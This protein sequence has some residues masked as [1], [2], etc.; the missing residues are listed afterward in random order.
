MS[1]SE[2]DPTGSW[3]PQECT[4]PTVERPVRVAEFDRLFTD[5]VR[6]ADRPDPTRLMLELEPTAEVAVE[7]AGLVARETACCGF[8]TFTLAATS[9]RLRLEVAVPAGHVDVLDALAARAS[10]SAGV[11]A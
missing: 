1:T 4:L 8:F 7:A 6:V 9:G 2:F 11:R 3:V 5:A 10:G